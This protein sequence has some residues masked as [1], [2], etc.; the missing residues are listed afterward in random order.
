LVWRDERFKA[1]PAMYDRL[2][3]LTINVSFFDGPLTID[4]FELENMYVQ[5]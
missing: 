3:L 2:I 4:A 5:Q 1:K